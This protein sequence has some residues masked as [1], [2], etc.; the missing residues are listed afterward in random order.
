MKYALICSLE[1]YKTEE[2]CLEEIRV[3]AMNGCAGKHAQ[4]RQLTTGGELLYLFSKN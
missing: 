3:R 2:N 1:C 4:V